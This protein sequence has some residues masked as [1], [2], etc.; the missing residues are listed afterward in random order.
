M[1]TKPQKPGLTDATQ[2]LMDQ[3]IAPR[4]QP[5][6]T[7]SWQSRTA[8]CRE[9]SMLPL[10][11]YRAI[12]DWAVMPEQCRG[13]MQSETGSSSCTR[14]IRCRSPK[15]SKVTVENRYICLR[16][17]WAA[18]GTAPASA[19]TEVAENTERSP[20]KVRRDSARPARNIGATSARLGTLR[21]RKKK[22][23]EALRLDAERRRRGN[24][25]PSGRG[26][27]LTSTTSSVPLCRYRALPLQVR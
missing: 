13:E 22:A 4:V 11:R 19:T 7:V 20:A 3:R 26:G 2:P 25:S 18:S 12:S 15:H 9:S 8:T 1:T 5:I 21:M 24:L 16:I 23:E 27:R 17:S 10:P 14:S 6:S